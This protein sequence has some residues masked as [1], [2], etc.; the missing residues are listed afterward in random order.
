MNREPL[1]YIIESQSPRDVFNN[2]SEGNH[3]ADLLRLTGVQSQY[4]KV[5]DLEHFLEAATELGTLVEQLGSRPAVLHISA[6]GSAAGI[7]LTSGELVEWNHLRE[8]LMPVNAKMEGRLIVCM[9]SCEGFAGCR[10][11]MAQ[12][13]TLPFLGIVG[14]T[15]KPTWGDTAV[16]FHAFYHLYA[17]GSSV[18]EA[19]AGMCA[20]SGDPGFSAIL[21]EEARDAYLRVLECQLTLPL[22]PPAQLPADSNEPLPNS[23]GTKVVTPASAPAIAA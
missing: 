21:A 10:M 6:H 12:Q 17:K 13:R 14:H 16:A 8:V 2:V 20:A 1:L 3:L 22:E 19:V 5:A 15:G 11:A 23:I 7:G 4:R 18:A 9:S